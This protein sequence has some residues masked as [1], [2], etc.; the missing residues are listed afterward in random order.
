MGFLRTLANVLY[1]ATAE[2]SAERRAREDAQGFN[3]YYRT[4]KTM[5]AWKCPCAPYHRF[6]ALAPDGY[7]PACMDCGKTKEVMLP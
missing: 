2:T 5:F 7:T 6:G 4:G 3:R 1:E